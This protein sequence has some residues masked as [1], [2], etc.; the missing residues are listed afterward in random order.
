MNSLI[1]NLRENDVP[2]E[3]L[4]EIEA[5]AKWYSKNIRETPLDRALAKV[6]KYLRDNPLIAV[7]FDNGVGFCVMKRSA[8]AEKQEKVLDCEQFKKL[9]K[10]CDNIVKKKEKKL[11]EE[12]LNMR[13]KRK[14]PVKVYEAQ[15]S[16]G[17]QP[18]SLY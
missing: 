13:K 7:Y 8:Y 2:G 11:N 6:Q 18:A 16:T 10:S 1:R 5:A 4:F 3:K 15:R 12:L 14:I 17:A 9:E